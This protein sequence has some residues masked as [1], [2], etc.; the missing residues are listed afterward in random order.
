[1]CSDKMS[2]FV[3]GSEVD[4]MQTQLSVHS[5]HL[6]TAHPWHCQS[7]NLGHGHPE[8]LIGHAWAGNPFIVGD[9]GHGTMKHSCGYGY[10]YLH[11]GGV[12]AWHL[13]TA[14]TERFCSNTVSL[15]CNVEDLGLTCYCN[16][17]KWDIN[18]VSLLFNFIIYSN[19]F[20]AAIPTWRVRATR[21][22]RLRRADTRRC[23]GAARR[24]LAWG[25]G[26]WAW[27]WRGVAVLA[28]FTTLYR[29]YWGAHHEISFSSK[30]Q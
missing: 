2:I 14:G 29:E 9:R 30:G 15:G 6:S 8:L 16:A 11:Y 1:M 28:S 22:R 21:W 5:A 23:C 3:R 19:I 10:Y 26:C 4:N 20:P 17:I 13:V 7:R 18:I 27:Q 24:G 12:R 25:R